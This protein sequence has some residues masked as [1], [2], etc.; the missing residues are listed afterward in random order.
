MTEEIGQIRC[1][2]GDD[3][4]ALRK[5]LVAFL[6]SED[7]IEVVGQASDGTQLLS[8]IERRRPDVTVT[9]LRMPGLNGIEICREVETRGL[10]TAVVLYTGF[11]EP[12]LLESALEAGARGFVLKSGPPNDLLRAVR[13]AH[14]DETYVD[15][16]LTSAL[17]EHRGRDVRSV[18]SRREKEV[19]QHLAEGMTT[20]DVATQLFL[21]PA[22]V[23]SYT[24]SAIRKL[25]TR[26]RTHAVA[27]ALRLE[28]IE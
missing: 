17:L 19:L 5:G 2:I 8:M 7:D 22:T 10:P 23:R 16:T 14:N 6:E 18:L 12:Q 11:G 21:S 15:A 4:E 1:L 9:D 26:N 27:Q 24:E 13:L 20:E 28:L 25:E 3:H